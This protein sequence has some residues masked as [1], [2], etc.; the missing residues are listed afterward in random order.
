MDTLDVARWQF[1]ITTVYHFIFVPLTIGLAPLV[2]IMQTAWVRTGNERWLRLTKFFGKLLLINFAIGVATGIVQEFQFG[3][4]WSEYSRFVGDVFGAPLAMEALAAFFV[5]STFLGLWIFGWDKLPKKIHLACIWAVAIATNLSAFFI[6]AANSWMQH[7]VGSIYNE[8]TGR[9]EMVDIGA[10]LS[11]PT[12]LAAFP[13]TIAAAFLTAGTFVAG[14]AAWWMVRLVRAGQADKA[15]DVYRPAVVLG[16]VVML[17][18]GVGVALSGDWQAKL[19]FDQQPMKMSSAEALCQ[20]TEGGAPFSILA[21]GDLSNSCEGVNHVIEIPGLTSFMATGD[22]NAPLPGVENLQA[23]YEEKYGFTDDEGNPISYQPNLLVTYW[24]FRLMIGFGLGSAALA[25][26]ALW[27]TRKGR[28]NGNVWFGRLGIVALV[29]PFLASSF[30]WIFTEMGRQPWVVA[31]NPNPSGVDGVWLLTARGVSTVTSAGT[32]LTSLIAFTL[33]YGVLAVF[34][35]RLMHRY[36]IEGVA[37]TEHDP[38]PDNPDND[39]DAA[40]RPLS[41]AY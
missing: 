28:V 20:T 32:I 3:M 15:R 17:V 8:T 33:L 12:V 29:T 21:I 18:S 22:F 10:V 25:L 11:N 36:T 4:A 35:Y 13:H 41:F 37:D 27:V 6:L 16:V 40:D 1:G 39:P 30:G 2:A 23:E 31:P 26:V 24:S 38:S 34:W 9:A 7:P 14:I 19:M 5:E